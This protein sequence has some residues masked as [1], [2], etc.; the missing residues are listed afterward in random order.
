MRSKEILDS[1]STISSEIIDSM[2]EV[3]VSFFNELDT[4]KQ[5]CSMAYVSFFNKLATE[6]KK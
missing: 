2:G 1:T 6:K 3:S 5:L 4:G